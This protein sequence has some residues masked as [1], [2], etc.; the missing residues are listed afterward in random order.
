MCS[1]LRD[2]FLKDLLSAQELLEQKIPGFKFNLGFSGKGYLQG[3]EDEDDGDQAILENANKFT[4][5]GHLF[6]HEQPHKLSLK[7]LTRS[8]IR[9]KKFAVVGFGLYKCHV[10]TLGY[11]WIGS[12]EEMEWVVKS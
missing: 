12:R 9:N 7:Q 4:W 1:Q 3:N 11:V 8:M 5:F 6:D 10:L 2:L